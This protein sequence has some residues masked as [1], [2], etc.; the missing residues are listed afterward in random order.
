MSYIDHPLRT[1]LYN[2]AKDVISHFS[3]FYFEIHAFQE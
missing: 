2:K 3:I 1:G